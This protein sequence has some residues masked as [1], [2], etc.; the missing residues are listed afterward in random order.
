MSLSSFDPERAADIAHRFVMA[1]AELGHRV[2]QE[3]IQY[4]VMEHEIAPIG[5][6]VN[7]R[8]RGTV[9][10]QFVQLLGEYLDEWIEALASIAEGTEN[11]PTP[12]IWRRNSIYLTRDSSETEIIVAVKMSCV[13]AFSTDD[14]R[15][16]H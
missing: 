14:L 16:P 9:D 5:L 1:F 13:N 3:Q 6:V 8:H 15:R 12:A 11:Q 7:P 4:T 2:A 10:L